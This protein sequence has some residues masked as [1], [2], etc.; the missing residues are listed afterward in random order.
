MHQPHFVRFLSRSPGSPRSFR[1]GGHR[2]PAE[3]AVYA[4]LATGNVRAICAVLDRIDS[5][6][7]PSPIIHVHLCTATPSLTVA[8]ARISNPAIAASHDAPQ[9]NIAGDVRRL[10][11]IVDEVLAQGVWITWARRCV[12]RSSLNC[13]RVFAS[14]LRL[15]CR[16]RSA[17]APPG[18]SRSP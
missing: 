11:D 3:Q 16:T 17:S 5:L 2:H 12:S 4:V 6:T 15:R 14:L 18:S 9:F 7:I 8:V 10:W 13:G 1:P